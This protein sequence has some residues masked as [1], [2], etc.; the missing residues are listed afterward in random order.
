MEFNYE[1][2]NEVTEMILANTTVNDSKKGNVPRQRMGRIHGGIIMVMTS[3]M[4]HILFEP[5]RE[6][7][8]LFVLNEERPTERKANRITTEISRKKEIDIAIAN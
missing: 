4:W 2:P 8:W 3:D 1:L 6:N 7:E 5:A